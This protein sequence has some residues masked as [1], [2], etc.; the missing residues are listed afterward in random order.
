MTERADKLL[1]KKGLCKSRS[2]AKTLIEEGK[3][4]CG[5]KPV[6]KPSELLDC[7]A[8]IT[9]TGDMKFVSRGGYKL[10]G[11]LDSFGIDVSGDVCA[12]I[13][14]STGGFTDCLLQRGAKKVYAV[15]GGHS[16]LDPSLLKDEHVISIEGFNAKNLSPATTGEL[17]DTVVMDVSFISQTLLHK[18]VFD[19]L[20]PGG[21]FISLIKPQFEA[22]KENIG[23]GGIAKAESYPYV[24]SSVCSSAEKCG[25]KLSSD[26][27]ESPV[28]GGDGNTEFLAL[29]IKE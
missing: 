27:I 6:F 28:K 5:A 11:A 19:I 17:C 26:I 25:L 13:G 4:M 8:K 1:F 29:F 12:D 14:A 9:V 3:V 18:N 21:K 23:K 20:K 7:D 10:E 24:K 16:Q 15:E 22:G 2:A